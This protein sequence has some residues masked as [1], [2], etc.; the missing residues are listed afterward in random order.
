MYV[1]IHIYNIYIHTYIY[2]ICVRVCVCELMFVYVHIVV[3]M[4]TWAVLNMLLFVSS[5]QVLTLDEA[6]ANDASYIY[7]Y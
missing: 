7:I 4:Y 5:F 3:C 2:T 6:I 1:Y